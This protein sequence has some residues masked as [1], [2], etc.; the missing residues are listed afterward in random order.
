MTHDCISITHQAE[1]QGYRVK[2]GLSYTAKP[3]SNIWVDQCRYTR[4]G[5]EGPQLSKISFKLP[6][7]ETTES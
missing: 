6:N 2:V 3:C 4:K 5:E 7:M 1:D